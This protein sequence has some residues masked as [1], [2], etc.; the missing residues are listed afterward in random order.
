M[1]LFFILSIIS[2]PLFFFFLFALC[3]MALSLI[4]RYPKKI[5]KLLWKIF[6]KKYTKKYTLIFWFFFH[7]WR[8][9]FWK[10]RF[11]WNGLRAVYLFVEM[12][13]LNCVRSSVLEL[14]F[15]FHCPLPNLSGAYHLVA[16]WE[17]VLRWYTPCSMAF[18]RFFFFYFTHFLEGSLGG[19]RI[20]A[21]NCCLSEF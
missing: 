10:L 8:Y 18:L 1:P 11:C 17:C 7:P 14:I 5:L 20:L 19:Y 12:M 16:S 13:S 9:F 3:S 4:L 6:F 15:L 2:F 21:V